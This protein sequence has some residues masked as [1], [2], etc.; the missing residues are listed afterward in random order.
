MLMLGDSLDR[1]AL[2]FLHAFCSQHKFPDELQTDNQY[3]AFY[4]AGVLQIVSLLCSSLAH[5]ASH[6]SNY[7]ACRCIT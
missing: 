1:T 7:K 3:E 2:E 5:L 6:N 4:K